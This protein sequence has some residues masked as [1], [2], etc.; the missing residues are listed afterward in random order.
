MLASDNILVAFNLNNWI[1]INLL[2]KTKRNNNFLSVHVKYKMFAIVMHAHNS[3]CGLQLKL[4]S[5]FHECGAM[6]K[7]ASQFLHFVRVPTLLHLC[8]RMTTYVVWGQWTRPYVWVKC[9][10]HTRQK[11]NSLLAKLVFAHRLYM[12]A[13]VRLGHSA[14]C[15][16]RVYV[17]KF[18]IY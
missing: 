7:T 13:V 15:E 10:R 17:H 5:V 1:L 9:S 2:N 18:H 12:R 11:I 16:W 6:Y 3:T 14:R 8:I 4:P